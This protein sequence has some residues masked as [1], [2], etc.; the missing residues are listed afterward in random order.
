MNA[1]AQPFVDA[2]LADSETEQ[3]L[4]GLMI[5]GCEEGA[6]S[7]AAG[8]A[9]SP[10]FVWSSHAEIFT[11]ILDLDNAQAA[12]N[13][14]TIR[15]KLSDKA[16]F[17]EEGAL[18]FIADLILGARAY[19]NSR[20]LCR[21]TVALAKIVH[22]LALRRIADQELDLARDSIRVL[23]T[24]VEKALRGVAEVGD[25][26][27]ALRQKSRFTTAPDAF[28][29]MVRRA[30]DAA[31]GKTVPFVTTGLD[32]LDEA[33]GGLHAGNYIV[34][35]G[36]PGMGKSALGMRTALRASL[37]C[38][39]APEGRPVVFFSLEMQQGE[40]LERAACEIDYDRNWRDPISYSWLRNGR[41][42]LHHV[43]RIART[44][45]A[46]TTNLS[47]YD[48][49]GMTIADMAAI[50]MQH[51]KQA[52]VMGLVVIDHIHMV[53]AGDRYRGT[54]VQ[55]VTEISKGIK[56]LAKSL[57]WPVVALAQ[58]NRGVETR[59]D[60]HP[61][62]S[63]LRESG[64]IEEDADCVVSLYREAYYIDKKRPAAGS[65]DPRW[66]EWLAEYEPVRNKLELGVLKNR[67]GAETSLQVFC[68]MRASAIRDDAPGGAR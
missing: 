16:E 61:T 13:P 44:R 23:S 6:I 48:R 21:Q 46:I 37:P 10:D 60:K 43:E 39:Q 4:L 47:I 32:R 68:D 65:H 67:H 55:E 1:M 36:R 28:D 26:A 62:L 7:A 25:Q 59:E 58:L 12:I 22:D 14:F 29:E 11:A 35:A 38:Q 24:P 51:A 66:N 5:A 18:G 45:D 30:E 31:N 49:G 19:A 42:K 54:K 63:D 2:Q 33:L 50:A 9:S 20:D 17:G 15:G 40:L 57:G 64:S 34:Y 53:A 52:K 56:N 27:L 3:A 41:V 8:H